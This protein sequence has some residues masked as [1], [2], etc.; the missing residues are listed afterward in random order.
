MGAIVAFANQKGGVGKTTSAV[1]IAAALAKRGKKTLLIDLDPQGNA[2]SG[3]GIAKKPLKNT[4][5]EVLIG[6]CGAK[7]AILPTV[8]PNLEIMPA[9]M[10]LAGADTELSGLENAEY[11]LKTALDE[12]L[13]EYRYI[14]IDCPPA[15]NR[16]T[17][18][19]LSAANGVVIPLQSE[20]FALEGLSQLV[21]SVRK[22]KQLFNPS[23]EITG[24]LLTMHTKRFLLASQVERELKRY[25]DDKLFKTTISRS[26]K[27]SEAPGYG[28]PICLYDPHGKGSREYDE[29]AR[30]LSYRI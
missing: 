15:L 18:N 1:N 2:T 12:V 27:L 14:L 3:L 4:V 22:V 10:S 30:E 17:V 7:E 8:C 6:K 11:R 19:A 23:L 13:G 25:Y 28:Q 20:Y 29:V 26:V 24:I 21:L 5:Y 16:L 9:T